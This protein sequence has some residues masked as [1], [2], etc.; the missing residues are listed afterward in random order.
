MLH[1]LFLMKTLLITHKYFLLFPSSAYTERRLPSCAPLPV[2]RLGMWKLGGYKGK[3]VYQ[4]WSNGYSMPYDIVPNHLGWRTWKEET[5]VVMTSA[6][7]WICC[8]WTC[9]YWREAVN[10]LSVLLCF[11]AWLLLYLLN[12]IYLTHK[13][14]HFHLPDSLRHPTWESVHIAVW[15]WAACQDQIT[16][17]VFLHCSY[18]TGRQLH[19]HMY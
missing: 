3:S 2:R 9:N 4:D 13:F 6:F 14:F 12:C 18:F 8:V 7:Q 5:F 19:F 11:C 15:C 17:A 10:E 1:F 16:T